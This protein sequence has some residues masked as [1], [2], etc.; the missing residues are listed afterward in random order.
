MDR[1][2]NR[3]DQNLIY[4]RSVHSGRTGNRSPFRARVTAERWAFRRSGLAHFPQAISAG[5]EARGRVGDTGTSPPAVLQG[6]EPALSTERRRQA[7][8]L[9]RRA[10]R[11]REA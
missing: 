4:D 6:G 9:D 5:S 10:A 7:A 2:W 3:T 11:S 1:F 8:R